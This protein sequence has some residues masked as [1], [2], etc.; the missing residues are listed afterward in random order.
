MKSAASAIASVI[1]GMDGVDAEKIMIR[2]GFTFSEAAEVVV[3][4]TSMSGGVMNGSV[5]SITNTIV[6][7]LETT[8]TI[9]EET[10]PVIKNHCE[11]KKLGHGGKCVAICFRN[12]LKSPGVMVD[13]IGIESES[14]YGD[15]G[16][17][18]LA[19]ERRI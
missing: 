17:G 1:L 15:D 3:A 2:A 4:H 11:F 5:L 10:E 9:E 18:R 7:T 19:C 16:R 13:C 8:E 14:D 6:S 12:R